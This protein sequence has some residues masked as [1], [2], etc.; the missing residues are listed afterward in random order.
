MCPHRPS[1]TRMHSH[2]LSCTL[3]HSHALSRTLMHSHQGHRC[4]HMAQVLAR[5]CSEPSGRHAEPAREVCGL[6]CLREC[7]GDAA[8]LRRCDTRA[9]RVIVEH[10]VVPFEEDCLPVRESR[11]AVP[12][13]S[14]VFSSLGNKCRAT[15]IAFVVVSLVIAA[16]CHCCKMPRV[17]HSTATQLH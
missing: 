8:A 12:F 2:A 17:P 6:R 7:G 10:R 3:M 11:E 5:L 9:K 13:R 1:C 4:S 14:S 15:D 16:C